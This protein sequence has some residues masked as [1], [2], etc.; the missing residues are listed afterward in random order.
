MKTGATMQHLVKKIPLCLLAGLASS[1]ALDM[2]CDDVTDRV[3]MHA[4][5]KWY[6]EQ[7]G[8]L[9]LGSE[10]PGTGVTGETR[11]LVPPQKPRKETPVPAPMSATDNDAAAMPMETP[12]ATSAKSGGKCVNAAGVVPE[13]E[14]A[15]AQEFAD[16]FFFGREISLSPGSLR[17]HGLADFRLLL[18][19][20]GLNCVARVRGSPQWRCRQDED[21]PIDVSSDQ[22]LA[23]CSKHIP[24]T[25]NYRTN[26]IGTASGRFCIYLMMYEEKPS[27]DRSKSQPTNI[28]R[29][30]LVV[31]THCAKFNDDTAPGVIVGGPRPNFSSPIAIDVARE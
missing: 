10:K 26:F 27:D 17:V 5:S 11:C 28:N 23:R 29:D 2:K 7:R 9:D 31:E 13:G 18:L 25:E 14:P 19:N 12:A 4:G 3:D 24:R 22:T 16:R 21:I 15:T 30:H 6:L 8:D 20:P 1:C